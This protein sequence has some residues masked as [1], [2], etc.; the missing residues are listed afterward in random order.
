MD[1]CTPLHHGVARVGGGRP[2]AHAVPRPP[3][4]V[5]ARS[6]RHPDRASEPQHGRAVQVD[7][8]KPALKAPGTKRLELIYD[9][10]LSNF[11]F[12]FNLRRYSTET[13]YKNKYI[14]GDAPARPQARQDDQQMGHLGAIAESTTS[15]VLE[16][17]QGKY[18]TSPDLGSL[19]SP[20]SA[21]HS[22]SDGGPHTAD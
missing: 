9:G 14:G 5:P 2:G 18:S 13:F 11:A 10:P 7:P 1:E 12:N 22:L 15:E 3:Q 21:S 20:D 16:R 4:R 19:G 17:G 6:A 8:I